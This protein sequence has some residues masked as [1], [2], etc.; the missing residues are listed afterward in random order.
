MKRSLIASAGLAMVGLA[1]AALVQRG[2]AQGPP[3]G[4][5]PGVGGVPNG[6]QPLLPTSPP[7]PQAGGARKSNLPDEWQERPEDPA[8]NNDLLLTP[9][10]GPWLI[11][12]HAY[13][14]SKAPSLARALALE[15]RQH[16]KQPAFV[17]NYGDDERK[18]ELERVYREV[19]KQKE[20]LRQAGLSTDVPIRVPHMFIRVQC[21]VLLGGYKD[22]DAA[23]RDVDRIK[24]LP[25]LDGKRFHLPG[26]LIIGPKG[27]EGAAVNAFAHAFPVRN[28]T[29]EKQKTEKDIQNVAILRK[30]NADEELSLFHCPKGYTLAVKQ[31]NLPTVV[32]SKEKSG[33]LLQSLGLGG[34]SNDRTDAAKHNAHNLAELLRQGKWEAYALH[35]RFYSIV[36]VGAYD[37]MDDPR[38]IQ[39]Q[40]ELGRLNARLVSRDPSLALFP[41]GI[42]MP[43]PR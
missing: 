15:L 7:L 25:P 35:T 27:G 9:E 34:K 31:F 10:V 3:Y 37:S 40:Q 24:K 20:A 17:W 18:A 22:F 26:V 21:G 41:K 43:V 38:I 5:V 30:L 23:R 6:L 32:E 4:G 29:W 14:E 16:Y 12:V 36:T 28:P 2:Q 11:Y 19:K 39:D 42:L 33:G 1:V 13:S 8:M